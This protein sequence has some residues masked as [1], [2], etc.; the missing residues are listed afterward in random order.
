M[1]ESK[2]VRDWDRILLRV[3]DGFKERLVR[4]ATVNRRPLNTEIMLML[5]QVLDRPS[6]SD[7]EVLA[8]EGMRLS[9]E[10]ATSRIHQEAMEYRLKAVHEE[11]RARLGPDVYDVEDPAEYVLRRQRREMDQ[12]IRAE[13]EEDQGQYMADIQRFMDEGASQEEAGSRA[14][15]LAKLRWESDDERRARG[16]DEDLP[17]SLKGLNP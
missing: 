17:E 8:N 14:L 1:A 2:N 4:R 9:H 16:P 11:L 13:I 6:H 7:L 15:D 3:P 12:R 5:E 10:L